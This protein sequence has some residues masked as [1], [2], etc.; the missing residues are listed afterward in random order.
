MFG[1]EHQDEDQMHVCNMDRSKHIDH[2]CQKYLEHKV[3]EHPQRTKVLGHHRQPQRQ[4][5][6]FSHWPSQVFLKVSYAIIFSL[7]VTILFPPP[8]SFILRWKRRWLLMYKKA[9][10]ESLLFQLLQKFWPSIAHQAKQILVVVFVHLIADFVIAPGLV[11]DFVIALGLVVDF[12][13]LVV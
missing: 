6:W 7:V 10:S 2:F 12:V 8:L 9:K 13:H 5:P 1:C 3:E 4:P 11:A